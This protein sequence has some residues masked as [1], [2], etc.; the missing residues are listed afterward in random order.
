MYRP[1]PECLP[2]GQ[3][4]RWP[5]P[6]PAP[7]PPPRPPPGP[8]PAPPETSPRGMSLFALASR[9]DATQLRQL[10]TGT[11]SERWAI[12]VPNHAGRTP[13]YI[14][15]RGGHTE[16]ALILLEAGGASVDKAK[17]NGVTALH[18]ACHFGHADTARALCAAGASVN[19]DSND[20]T[21][22]FI[23]CREGH[24]EVVGLLLDAAAD[25]HFRD[26][27]DGATP[28]HMA[29]MMKHSD[30]ARLML[31]ARAAVDASADNG[32]SPMRIAC[33]DDNLPLVCL[34]S[35]H[36]AAR[37]GGRP[38]FSAERIAHRHCPQPL[39]G[40]PPQCGPLHSWL[41]RSRLWSTPLHHVSLLTP[42]HTRSLL[43]GGADLHA[44][45]KHHAAPATEEVV[46]LCSSGA[47]PSPQLP[48]GAAPPSPLELAQGMRD[49]EPGFDS[50]RLV[51]QAAEEWSPA[52]HALWPDALRARAV[53]LMRLGWLL[54]R[55]TTPPGPFVGEE[56]GLSDA[57]QERV[58]PL[59]LNR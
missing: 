49:G 35:L 56:Q 12:D 20:G 50:A 45:C 9:N 7:P 30:A 37:S 55:S 52:S 47:A 15:C 38:P 19:L 10:L 57:W 39:L 14:A 40:E 48:S 23:A 58:I 43:R 16:A 18:V 44:R 34:L 31:E 36:G 1:D 8:P 21:A 22:L 32:L 17:E 25:V 27:V 51:M 3:A 54:A 53:V 6:L 5:P 2:L 13:L 46:P 33:E 11:S 41:A 24:A 28:L 29:C 4:E 42:S 59:A 26:P